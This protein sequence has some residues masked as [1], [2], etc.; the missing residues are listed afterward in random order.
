MEF[1]LDLVGRPAGGVE[2]GA[3]PLDLEEAVLKLCGQ[4]AAPVGVV[5]CLLLTRWTF[6]RRSMHEW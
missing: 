3:L 2:D 1:T 5:G 6:W 4:F